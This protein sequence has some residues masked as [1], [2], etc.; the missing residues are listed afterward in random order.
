[1]QPSILTLFLICLLDGTV[2]FC[3]DVEEGRVRGFAGREIATPKFVFLIALMVVGCS[4]QAQTAQ[5]TP[6]QPTPRKE[7]FHV[8]QIPLTERQIQGAIA[9]ARGVKETTEV[10]KEGINELRPDTVAKLNAVA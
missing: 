5:V 4:V 6:G 8:K 3:R 10:A 1:M 2:P 7:V 9:A